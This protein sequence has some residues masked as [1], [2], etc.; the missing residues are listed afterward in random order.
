MKYVVCPI[1]AA[2]NAGFSVHYH[3]MNESDIVLNE[4][5]VMS[6]S[7]PGYTLAQRA[8]H[9]GGRVYPI[10]KIKKKFNTK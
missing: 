3:L 7:V 4:K 2:E 9:L 8:S 1:S 6:S 5:E 10:A